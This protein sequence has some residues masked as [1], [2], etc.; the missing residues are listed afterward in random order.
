MNY[1]NKSFSKSST[2]SGVISGL[3]I[4][5]IYVA[6]AYAAT[7]PI[8]F[9]GVTLEPDHSI[10]S[11]GYVFRIN[12]QAPA[13]DSDM[14][15]SGLCTV[16]GVNVAN[17][18]DNR[19]G[20]L[21]NLVYTVGAHDADVPSGGIPI[22]CT[23]QSPST[24]DILTAARFTDSNQAGVDTDFVSNW[25]A[26]S[27]SP[28]SETIT[29]TTAFPTNVD[30]EY[31]L[32]G[33]LYTT[34]RDTPAATSHSITIPGLLPN[35]SYV[36]E[37]VA[38]TPD[39]IEGTSPELI[40]FKTAASVVTP[41]GNPAG[42]PVIKPGSTMGIPQNIIGWV[43]PMI[44]HYCLV[45][46]HQTLAEFQKTLRPPWNND[47]TTRTWLEQAYRQYCVK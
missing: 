15:I 17:T 25:H 41:P 46:Q 42:S 16:N 30:I 11:A 21:Y 44:Q 31:T 32:N 36:Y 47:S 7:G 37:V 3:A 13:A 1:F 19:T 40:P 24:H 34:A 9:S 18:L 35:T 6:Q 10:R 45:R 20:G 23:L 22:S 12:L 26:V 28:T 38:T 2:F 4:A 5:V 8:P 39:G 43:L 27:A 14:H 33:H 29:A